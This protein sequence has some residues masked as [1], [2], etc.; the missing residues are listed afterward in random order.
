MSRRF[1]RTEIRL[2][3]GVEPGH[4]ARVHP[5][6]SPETGAG[7]PAYALRAATADDAAFIAEMTLEAFNWS[8]DRPAFTLEQFWADPALRKYVE[9][10]P[11]PGE[12]GVVAVARAESGKESESDDPAG[13]PVGAAW[14][15]YF[16]ADKPGYGFVAEDV[17]EVSIA[18]APDWRGRG[19]G[20]AL[21]RAVVDQ[22]RAAG[23]PRLSLSVERANHAAAL[24]AAEGFEV[25]GGDENADTMVRKI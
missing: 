17:P 18:V 6:N 23:V 21:I 2:A 19:L 22:A 20:R 11:A 25:V 16:P 9:G 12:Q 10:W 24:Y 7:R 5:A 8:P 15:R 13:R 1:D 14:W 3:M 4:T